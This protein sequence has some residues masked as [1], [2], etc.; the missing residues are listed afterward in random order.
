MQNLKPKKPV[1]KSSNLQIEKSGEIKPQCTFCRE[2]HFASECPKFVTL[3]ARKAEINRLERC[4]KCFGKHTEC[5]R[6][7]VC[8]LCLKVNSHHR[9]LCPTLYEG[10]KRNANSAMISSASLKAP[11]SV[12]L[13]LSRTGVHTTMKILFINPVTNRQYKLRALLD[14]GANVSFISE[15]AARAI[16][17]RIE[18]FSKTSIGVFLHES[19]VMVNS[20]EAAVIMT[21]GKGFQLPITLGT[22]PNLPQNVTV[23]D[24]A[25]FCNEYPQYNH[26]E[27]APQ[28][29]TEPIDVVLGSDVFWYIFKP[30][31]RIVVD[32]TVFLYHTEFGHIIVGSTKSNSPSAVYYLSPKKALD[33]ICSADA[34]GTGADSTKRGG[35][36]F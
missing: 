10:D 6:A 24:L 23:F 14:Q 29:E 15:T 32:P 17:L 21:N 5:T 3:S 27:F 9:V 12:F 31:K 30:E 8:P 35:I 25:K 34:L 2:A 20:G 11:K 18:A 26:L 16:G 19:P 22:L 36:C 7:T 1:L 13:T 28:A 33:Q 4:D